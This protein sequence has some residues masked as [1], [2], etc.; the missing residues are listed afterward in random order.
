MVGHPAAWS[1]LP[2]RT[3]ITGPLPLTREEESLVLLLGDLCFPAPLEF[4]TL[5]G[6]CRLLPGDSVVSC[7]TAQMCLLQT[8]VILS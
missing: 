6:V 3:G 5:T 1:C 4:K 7:H 2:H 8:P